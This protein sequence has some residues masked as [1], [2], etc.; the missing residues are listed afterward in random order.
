MAPVGTWGTPQGALGRG[1]GENRA[2]RGLSPKP[3][4]SET[5]P[6]A[7][8]QGHSPRGAALGARRL[9]PGGGVRKR[10]GTDFET[11]PGEGALASRWAPVPIP[12]PQARAT[13]P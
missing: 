8:T 9:P 1:Q 2:G 12:S 6:A 11:L 4:A 3:T 13:A 7:L 10:P 5:F